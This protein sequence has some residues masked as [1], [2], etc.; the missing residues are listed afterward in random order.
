MRRNEL[1]S[2]AREARIVKLP[3]WFTVPLATSSPGPLS[4][5]IGSPVITDWS[6]EVCPSSTIPSAGIV[7]PG[8]TRITSPAA[9]VSAAMISSAP[10]RSTRA[11]LGV[12]RT[13]FS[14]PARAFATVRSS[15][16]APICM[17]KATS[18]AAKSSPMLTEAISAIETSRSALT[19]KAV[20]RPM[21]A[22]RIIG[23]PQSAIAIHAASKGRTSAPKK[24]AVSAAPETARNAASRFTPPH[25]RSS[26]SF[27]TITAVTLRIKNDCVSTVIIPIGVYV[28]KLSASRR[29]PDFFNF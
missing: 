5:G 4:A 21:K 19:S 14:M 9:T 17:M 2:P 29:R 24:L 1:F 7:S 28:S 12:R 25:S 3:Y 15:S 27:S 23:A 22:S 8:S 16:S 20:T 18:P 13:S 6:T 10:P 11:V 26:S